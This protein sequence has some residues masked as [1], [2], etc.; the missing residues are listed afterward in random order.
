LISKSE[1]LREVFLR[2]T[3][4]PPAGTA[5]EARKLLADTLTEVE[6]EYSGVANAPENWRTD[7][8]MYPPQDDSRREVSDWPTVTRYRS[9]WHNTYIAENGAI[10]IAA[11]GG[12]VLLTKAGADGRYVWDR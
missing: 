12:D 6:D 8:R 2:L 4:A 3:A 1:R 11:V 9:L 7:G 5:A 10:E